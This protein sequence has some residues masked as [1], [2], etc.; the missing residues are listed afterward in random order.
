MKKT[1]Q[2]KKQFINGA[3]WLTVSAL[4]LKIIGLIYKIPIS[5]LL[6][7][8]GM[9]YFNSAYTIYTFFY[10]VA[11][12]GIPKAISILVSKNEAESK[13]SS[14]AIF[15]VS[16]Y[17]FLI[18]GVI[19]TV[20]FVIFSPLL[21]RAIGNSGA[22][23][24]MYAVSP[25]LL[26]VC[27][28]GV[29]RGYLT[30]KMKFA[31]I[32]ISE[33]IGG[34][35]KLF[36]GL[37]FAVQGLKFNR[38]L[39]EICAY[40]I[41]GITLG[42]FLGLIYLLIAYKINFRGGAIASLAPRRIISDV[43]KIALPITCGAIVA[44]MSGIFDLSIIMNG[45]QRIGY[46][47]ALSVSLYGNYTTLAVP[48]L[49]LVTTLL[50]PI[51]T[52]VMPLLASNAAQ[53]NREEYNK[54]LGTALTLTSLLTAPAFIYFLF[55]AQDALTIIFEE[56]S[57]VIGFSMLAALAPSVLII[58]HLTVLNTALEADGR[59]GLSVFSLMLGTVAKFTITALLITNEDV[60]IL[61]AP[62]GT[63][64]SYMISLIVSTFA[65]KSRRE[66]VGFLF[67]TL[68]SPLICA[69]VGAV[70]VLVLKHYLT[71]PISARLFSIITSLLFGALY[72]VL[73]LLLSKKARQN[74]IKLVK[75]NK[76]P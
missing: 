8:E 17:T 2:S 60:A 74:I 34:I 58:G 4:I 62:I 36:F 46:S 14:D 51:S 71:F 61:A 55:F 73:L 1:I 45:L 13:D 43:L 41:L 66:S 50:M 44:G 16:F 29:V 31:P 48:M 39:T 25:S 33:L 68:I 59:V 30:G 67:S 23:S 76:K 11:T 69:S 22:L 52:A 24:A 12:G 37:F 38:P 7:D 75:F 15:K 18:I 53:K 21:S 28:G 63:S 49:S 19:L 47:N 72:L 6:G 3:I 42:S 54:N 57:A 27:A 70:T 5:Y 65:I 9:G 20:L 32:A 26:F 35:S 10:I 40:V 56:G 64:A